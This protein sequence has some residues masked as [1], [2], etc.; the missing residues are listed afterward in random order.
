MKFEV[1]ADPR[2]K[3]SQVAIS[4]KDG[5][6]HVFDVTP[7]GKWIPTGE[8]LPPESKSQLVLREIRAKV[9]RGGDHVLIDPLLLERIDE[10]LK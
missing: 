4:G 2:L 6:L 10:A 5:A 7:S 9:H 8:A 1:V 3:D